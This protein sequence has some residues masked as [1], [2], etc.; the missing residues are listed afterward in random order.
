MS[1]KIFS[2][3]DS[4]PRGTA[5]EEVTPGC[6]VLEGGAFRGL[7]TEGVLDALMEAGINFEC[8]IGVSAGAMNGICYVSGQIGRAARFSL[9]Y[10][11]DSRYVSWAKIFQRGG[12][13]N[14]RFALQ[15]IPGDPL[16]EE[17]FYDKR[18]RFVAEA[19][20]CWTGRPAYFDRDTCGDIFQA[21]CAS[22]GMPYV[23]RIVLVDGIPCLDG[24]CSDKLPY[25]WA[26]EEGYK[27]IVVLRAR[28]A[29]WRYPNEKPSKFARLYYRPYPRFA[30][31]LEWEHARANRE[32]EEVDRLGKEGRLFVISPSVYL[33]VKLL[34]P[35]MEKLGA[36]YYLGYDD[37]K[38][39]IGDLKRYLNN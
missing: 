3:I 29:D 13:L 38:N 32:Y 33:P 24:G 34:E 10:R 19:T 4:L 28:T 36:L 35:D 21:I 23:S 14:Y 12:P 27:K 15:H 37:G 11:H 30:E 39:V 26:M 25:K 1:S 7:Y 22:A 6:I 8:T 5:S 31:T 2:G 18:K 9:R 16:D 20:N 17:R